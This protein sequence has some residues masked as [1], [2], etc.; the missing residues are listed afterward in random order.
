M[1]EIYT[2]EGKG[3][4]LENQTTA[5]IVNGLFQEKSFWESSELNEHVGWQF[6]QA[7]YSLR[8]KGLKIVT[9]RLG[10]RRF[11]YRLVP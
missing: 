9:E 2:N 6:S 10:H 7:I 3:T 1:N 11:G 5:A 8:R 4:V